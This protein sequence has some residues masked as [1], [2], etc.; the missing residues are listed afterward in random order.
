[1][2]LK[3][4]IIGIFEAGAGIGKAIALATAEEGITKQI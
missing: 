1:M 4:K 2:L 3:D